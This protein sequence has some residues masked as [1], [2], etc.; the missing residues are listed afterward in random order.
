M[1]NFSLTAQ[2]IEKLHDPVCHRGTVSGHDFIFRNTLLKKS[3][4]LALG[5]DDAGTADGWGLFFDL[6]G[7][8]A[9]VP[10]RHPD[11][12]SKDFHASSRTSSAFVVHHKVE[13]LSTV[14]N[15]DHLAVL[16]AHVHDRPH[17]GSVH[18]VGPTGMAGDL[19]D[20]IVGPWAH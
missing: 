10:D 14:I 4:Y 16:S 17:F 1:T 19:G 20:A 12:I 3:H 8:G 15:I 9:N 2:T 18:E 5:K 13:N 7:A 11:E 6:E